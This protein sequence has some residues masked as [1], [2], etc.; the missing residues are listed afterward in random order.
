M[1]VALGSASLR[2]PVVVATAAVL[3][4]GVASLFIV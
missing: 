2:P 1:V 4:A 3:A